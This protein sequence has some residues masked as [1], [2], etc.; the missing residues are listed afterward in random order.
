L[1]VLSFCG[2]YQK[3]KSLPAE[4][5][6][7]KFLD[8]SWRALFPFGDS[9]AV[10]TIVFVAGGEL[11]LLTSTRFWLL[12]LPPAPSFFS[13]PM[14]HKAI[15][16]TQYHQLFKFHLHRW[17]ATFEKRKERKPRTTNTFD[18]DTATFISFQENGV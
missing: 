17:L 12:F 7:T 18:D 11:W 8:A 4:S 10:G 13:L 5:R 2:F 15:K 9:A 3:K 1:I 16:W 14:P 6:P